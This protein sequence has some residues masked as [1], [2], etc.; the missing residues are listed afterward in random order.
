MFISFKQEI[1]ALAAR[2][3]ADPALHGRWLNTLSYLEHCGA[4]KIAASAHPSAVKE[5]RL[6]HAAEEFRHA[7][8][9]KTQL[10]RIGQCC[11]DYRRS[12][13]LG[14]WATYHYLH[15]LDL[16]AS[17]QN[18][19]HAYLLTT[20]AIELRAAEL[21]PLYQE[22]LRKSGSK[23][24]VQSILLEEEEHLAEMERELGLAP[25]SATFIRAVCEEEGR[26]CELWLRACFRTTEIVYP[27]NL[28][29]RL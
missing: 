15:R 11:V 4:C 2:V 6:K 18:Q 21:Y 20:Y 17:R 16:F 9:L 22:A 8:Y 14:G 23:V 1:E 26:L 29:N 28:K 5:E 3:V 19:S 7:H 25:G 10:R 24:R 27:N 13:L 12:S